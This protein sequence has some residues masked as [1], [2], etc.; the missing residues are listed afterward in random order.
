MSDAGAGEAGAGGDAV[1]ELEFIAF[2]SLFDG[3]EVPGA[4]GVAWGRDSEHHLRAPRGLREAEAS[5][6]DG[7]DA[8]APHGY[9]VAALA[10]A[11]NLEQ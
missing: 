3:A 2:D 1:V 9:R 7:E 8:A 11:T 5:Q 6:P 4:R 10:L